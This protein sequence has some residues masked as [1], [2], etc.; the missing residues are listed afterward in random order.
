LIIV[1]TTVGS[2]SAFNAAMHLIPSFKCANDMQNKVILVHLTKVK[3]GRFSNS[4]KKQNCF[5]KEE[6][7]TKSVLA[8]FGKR[9]E[10]F[11]IPYRLLAVYAN[12]QSGV[13]SK[14]MKLI[15]EF[16]IVGLFVG[17]TKFHTPDSLR[18][19]IF[20]FNRIMGTLPDKFCMKKV[21]QSENGDK[22]GTV[23]KNTEYK[24]MLDLDFVDYKWY[25]LPDLSDQEV[26]ILRAEIMGS[27]LHSQDSASLKE[28]A[29]KRSLDFTP[30][31]DTKQ[32]NNNNQNLA[33]DERGSKT[34]RVIEGKAFTIRDE[35][36]A[37]GHV[38]V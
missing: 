3:P 7:R 8:Y 33:D 11:Q 13:E 20:H 15:D 26:S 38:N 27:D 14:L 10:A 21:I 34:P 1:D 4:E 37:D 32:V 16:D 35:N 19:N 18:C 5:T 2:A 24:N 23:Y 31:S 6:K 30:I 28:L 12:G 22:I 9:L 29:Q 25:S 36:I 17:S